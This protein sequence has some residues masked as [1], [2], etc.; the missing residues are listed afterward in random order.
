M[1]VIY[2]ISSSEQNDLCNF[3]KS[4]NGLKTLKFIILVKSSLR[5]GGAHVYFGGIF[6]DI[7][8]AYVFKQVAALGLITMC[9]HAGLE[10]SRVSGVGVLDILL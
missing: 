7:D 5:S 9:T 6:P 2:D 1:Y 10:F 4:M 3:L 8:R